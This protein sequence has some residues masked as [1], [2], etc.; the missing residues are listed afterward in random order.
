LVNTGNICK[1]KGLDDD[2]ANSATA[3]DGLLAEATAKLGT[4]ATPDGLYL[5]F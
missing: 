5:A 3:S 4:S 1:V 2:D